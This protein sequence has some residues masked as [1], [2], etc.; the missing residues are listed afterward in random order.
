MRY[1]SVIIKGETGEIQLEG[2]SCS[3]EA[4]ASLSPDI[5][6]SL[7][8][9]VWHGR[10]GL[11]RISAALLVRGDGATEVTESDWAMECQLH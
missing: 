10:R 11:C 8:G 2:L 9:R 4:K 6:G 1:P 5:W 7:M 3:W